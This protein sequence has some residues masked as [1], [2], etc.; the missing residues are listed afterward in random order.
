MQWTNISIKKK[1]FVSYEEGALIINKQG[2]I[3]KKSLTILHVWV[4]RSWVLRSNK[5]LIASPTYTERNKQKEVS[6]PYMFYMI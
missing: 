6:Y 4:L 1:L 3:C 5:N 2:E